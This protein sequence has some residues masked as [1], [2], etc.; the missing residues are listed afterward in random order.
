MNST[1]PH[2]TVDVIGGGASATLILAHL[3]KHK[4]A[5]KMERITV[6]DREGRFGRGVAYSTQNKL[7]LLNVRANNMSGF[8]DDM[9]HLVRWLSENGY[10]YKDTDFIPRMVYAEYLKT[11]WDEA[12]ADLKKSG[13]DVALKTKDIRPDES[14]ADIK[15]VATGNAFPYAPKGAEKLSVFDGYH[16][17]PWHVD[18]KAIQGDVIIPGTGLS[19]I[20][21]VMA[22]HGAE[23]TGKVT[24]ISRN[25][26]IPA[27]HTNPAS[28]PCFYTDKFPSTVLELLTDIRAHIVK[29]AKNGTPWQVVIDS[30]RPVT[31]PIWLSLSDKEKKKMKRLMAFWNIHRHRMA[32][33]ASTVIHDRIK[34][35]RLKIVKDSVERIEKGLNVIGRKNSYHADHVINCLGYGRDPDFKYNCDQEKQGVYTLGPALSGILFETVAMPEI[36]A[37]AER[38]A[39]EILK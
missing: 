34:S 35:G 31:N 14:K 6:Y 23:F 26:L 8:P 11:L 3:S 10:S 24:A 2:L 29:A 37:Q 33:E 13:C 9:A 19:M 27:T 16:L 1:N 18:Y 32:P 5:G 39:N 20:D 22:L 38:I 12:L 28:Y 15:I 7:H 30:L 4:N 36:R 17:H 25:G 21:T